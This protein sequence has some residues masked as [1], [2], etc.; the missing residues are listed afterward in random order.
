MF[1]C[2]FTH[3]HYID[4]ATFKVVIEILEYK[5]L[6]TYGNKT[7]RLRDL[8]ELSAREKEVAKGGQLFFVNN[9]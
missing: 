2:Y 4:E 1:T 8:H 6:H 9:K 7:E 5:K 3:A